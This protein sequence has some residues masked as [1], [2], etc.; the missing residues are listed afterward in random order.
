MEITN[1]VALVMLRITAPEGIPVPATDCPT[2]IF[3]VL[4][5]VKV[6]ELFTVVVLMTK[7][8]PDHHRI[9]VLRDN[10]FLGGICITSSEA[11]LVDAAMDCDVGAEFSLP[12]IMNG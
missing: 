3:A 1:V 5:T 6:V 10:S 9:M 12:L 8:A 11:D 2:A 4:A 7:D